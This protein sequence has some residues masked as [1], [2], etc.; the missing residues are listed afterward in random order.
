[1]SCEQKYD[2]AVATSSHRL[3][4]GIQ[5]SLHHISSPAICLRDDTIPRRHTHQIITVIVGV[6]VIVSITTTTM[7]VR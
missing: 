3:L 2:N 1:M 5:Y 4:F 6:F 7:T